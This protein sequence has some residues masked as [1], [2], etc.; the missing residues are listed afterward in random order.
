M[1]EIHTHSGNLR[2][3]SLSAVTVQTGPS[4]VSRFGEDTRGCHVP[5]H[6]PTDIPIDLPLQGGTVQTGYPSH[7][8]LPPPP[9]KGTP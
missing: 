8:N 6:A 7:P 5:L 2:C 4:T 1:Q 3:I 9:G